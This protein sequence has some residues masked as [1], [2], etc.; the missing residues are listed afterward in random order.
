MIEF[1]VMLLC[2]AHCIIRNKATLSIVSFKDLSPLH[3]VA[4][5]LAVAALASHAAVAVIEAK[6]L[7]KLGKAVAECQALC[8]GAERLGRN[9][10]HEKARNRAEGI[11][12]A[13]PLAG[14]R[15]GRVAG[16]N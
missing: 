15:V 11:A 1:Q 5:P 8:A 7:H 13:N 14:L 4:E 12:K 10:K 3:L 9:P 2:A 16:L 6:S